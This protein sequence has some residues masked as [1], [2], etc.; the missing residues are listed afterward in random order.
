MASI[1]SI[2]Q[3]PSIPWGAGTGNTR[4]APPHFAGSA[5][6]RTATF[7]QLEE[8]EEDANPNRRTRGQEGEDAPWSQ[9][10]SHL[11]P[12]PSVC[13]LSPAAPHF[14]ASLL[15]SLC[16]VGF[17]FFFFFLRA[18][19]SKPYS[20]SSASPRPLQAT[21]SARASL[22][23]AVARAHVRPQPS[24]ALSR[25]RPRALAPSALSLGCGPELLGQDLVPRFAGPPAST[26]AAEDV[27]P[28]TR[29]PRGRVGGPWRGGPGGSNARDARGARPASLEP[30]AQ[31][32]HLR[33]S[34][35]GLIGLKR[36]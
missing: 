13:P 35:C 15:S 28:G 16:S 23:P 24:P 34:L 19:Y 32:A 29:R 25:R 5:G 18:R 22:S 14:Q 7:W 1:Y 20:V 17:F 10:K 3:E 2:P 33:G 30:S 21:A 9:G 8:G 6:E 4:T 11:W 12:S 31:V 36:S 26:P 27:R